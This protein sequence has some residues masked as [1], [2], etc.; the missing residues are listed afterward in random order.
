[1][2]VVVLFFLFF[3]P[4]EIYSSPHSPCNVPEQGSKYMKKFLG[5]CFRK[6]PAERPSAEELLGYDWIKRAQYMRV[7]HQSASDFSNA[8]MKRA[9]QQGLSE[10]LTGI[11]KTPVSSP[12]Q[13]GKE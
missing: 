1:M 7:L 10:G 13:D 4:L 9:L 12:R 5:A 8:R 11:P 3:P 2:L 6:D